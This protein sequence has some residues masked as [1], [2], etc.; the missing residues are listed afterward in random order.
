MRGC[1]L[2]LIIA[3]LAAHAAS[4]SDASPIEPTLRA[5]S[6]ARC[7]SL[8]DGFVAMAG[9]N[10]CVKISGHISA[11]MPYGS[12]ADSA[13]SAR[14]R[15]GPLPPRIPAVT[16]ISGGLRFDGSSSAARVDFGALE[17]SAP[18]WVVDGQ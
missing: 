16:A 3:S 10:A 11:G 17:N 6:D 2:G 12:G 8:G 14:L 1:R 18:R 9:S 7:S 5:S 15:F 13:N 4:A